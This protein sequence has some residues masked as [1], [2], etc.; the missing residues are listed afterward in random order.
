MKAKKFFIIDGDFFCHRVIHGMRIVN[1]DITLDTSSEM[2]NFN[3]ALI[4]SVHATYDVFVNEHHNLIDQII[5][6]FDDRSWRKGVEPNKP[7]YVLD[8]QETPIGYKEN[9]KKMKEDSNLNYDNFHLC[10]DIFYEALK[11]ANI[12][13]VFKFEGAE[14]DDM[15]LMLKNKLLQE[16]IDNKMIV[17]CTDGDLKQLLYKDENLPSKPDSVIL[18]RNIRSGAAPEGEFVI[19]D[20]LYT[21][22][23]GN[24]NELG[25]IDL[26]DAFIKAAQHN[27][28]DF[29]PDYFKNYLFKVN[30]KDN[31]GKAN[32]E[33]GPG[34]GVSIATPTLTLLTKMVVGDKK[35]NIFPLFRWKTKT[36]SSIRNISENQLIKVFKELEFTFNDESAQKIYTDKVSLTKMLYSLRE[37]AKQEDVDIQLIGKHFVHNRK[38]LDI[39]TL[40]YIPT[41]LVD[42]FNSSFNDYLMNGILDTTLT[43]SLLTKIRE[44]HT[45]STN[46]LSQSLP[47]LPEELKGFSD[48]F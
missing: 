30:F 28:S 40:N 46:I 19:S 26:M 29:N 38:L 16:N 15:M 39:R 1:K 13:P 8:V 37:E 21:E 14:G 3:K 42:K 45:D 48:L 24:R 11:S 18:F 23:Y 35:D 22:L 12:F 36:G 2:N 4:N 7:Y 33:R 47:D 6:V 17:F 43:K 9:R 32:Y 41:T 31:S 34:T 5:F 44:D 20:E 27:E 25:K 10:K